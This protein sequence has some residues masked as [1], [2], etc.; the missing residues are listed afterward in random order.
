MYEEVTL[1]F[2]RE[3]TIND[4]KFVYRNCDTVH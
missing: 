4:S 1:P 3:I 2:H